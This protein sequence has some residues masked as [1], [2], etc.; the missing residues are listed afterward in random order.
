MVL[1]NHTTRELT[2]K[3]VYYGPG[4]SGKTTNLRSLH[5]RLDQASTGRL[6][7]LSTAQDRTIYFDLL[8]VELG[9][10]KGYAVRFQLCT[11]PGQVFYN[12]T[13]KLVLKGVDGIVFVVDSQWS[14]LSHNLESFQNLRDNLREAGIVPASI[15][16]VIQFN[17]RDLPGILSIEGLQESLGFR[18]LP[19]VEAVAPEGRGVVETFKLASKLTFV[20]LMRKLQRPTSLAVLRAEASL[21]GRSKP[22]LPPAAT[23]TP[24]PA[25]RPPAPITFPQSESPFETAGEIPLLATDEIF[26]IPLR[27]PEAPSPEELILPEPPPA[28]EEFPTSG[29]APA[30]PAEFTVDPADDPEDD[31]APGGPKATVVEKEPTPE[32][33]PLPE[34][35]AAIPVDL[36][37]EHPPEAR[38]PSEPPAKVAEEVTAD[39]PAAEDAVEV[40]QPALESPLP[41]AE[42]VPELPAVSPTTAEAVQVVEAAAPARTPADYALLEQRVAE[43]EGKLDRVLSA[44]RGALG[45][46]DASHEVRRA[47][48]GAE[49]EDPGI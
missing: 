37:A 23:P 28:A 29:A 14:M 43:L 20:D 18:E 19:F 2:A 17:K 6:L 48:S 46:N 39:A 32:P 30:G 7:S 34:V 35:D 27:V 26:G 3:I 25:A 38:Q 4:L 42:T 33:E 36:L 12:E 11:V 8:P 22:A 16:T 15:P 41:A 21:T 40:T 49:P 5:E 13:R 47:V 45:E 44:L 9:N 24:P 10:I 31:T 1:F